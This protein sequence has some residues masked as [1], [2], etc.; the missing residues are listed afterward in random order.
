MIVVTE[1]MAPKTKTLAGKPKISV[2]RQPPRPFNS[3]DGLGAYSVDPASFPPGRVIYCTDQWVVINDLYPKAS[4]HMLLLL[5][6]PTKNRLHPFDAF[7]DRSLVDSALTEL[8]KVRNMAASELRRRFGNFSATERARI[9]AM[10]ADPPLPKSELPAGR[11]WQKEIQSGVHAHPSMN[12]LHIH[13]LSV[14]MISP[15]MRHRNHYNSFKTPFLVPVEDFPLGPDHLAKRIG[16]MD[17]DLV[18]WRCGQN[19]GRNFAKLKE[20]LSAEFDKWKEE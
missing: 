12:H 9:A 10:N 6:D 17:A 4:V 3:R 20:H 7:E 1:L 13:V 8:V 14:D 2:P 16:N 5:R 11:D 19:F 15:C 18:C